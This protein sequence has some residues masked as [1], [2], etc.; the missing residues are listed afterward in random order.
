MPSLKAR[1][2]HSAT[3]I[4]HTP[5]LVEVVL[6]G[7]VPEVPKDVKTDADFPQIGN[8]VVLRFGEST[9]CV[10]PINIALS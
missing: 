9:S 7:G 6:F 5:T 3:A 10:C 2:S 1:Y 4:H 8:T